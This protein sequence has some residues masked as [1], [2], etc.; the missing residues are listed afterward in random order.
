MGVVDNWNWSFLGGIPATSTDQNPQVVY[1]QPGVYAVELVVSNSFGAST[2]I[3]TDLIKVGALP[4]ADFTYVDDGAGTFDFTVNATDVTNYLWDFGDG[5]TS[6]EVNPTHTYTVSGTY[7]VVLTVT[8]DCGEERITQTVEVMITSVSDPVFLQSL[9]L[10]PNPTEGQFVLIIE[11]AS[12]KALELNIL[13]VLGQTISSERVSFNGYLRQE[14]D[15]S[16]QPAGVY[17]LQLRTGGEVG[18]RKI[19]VE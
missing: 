12:E 18:Y 11:G 5:N 8:N 13:N 14:F 4:S 7:D 17:L 9:A 10:F 3:L 19:V 6:T 16:Q 15:L 2:I 1:N